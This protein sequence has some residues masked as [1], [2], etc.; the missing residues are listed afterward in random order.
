[1]LT[2]IKL[3]HTAIWAF[4]ATSILALPVVGIL[5]R[6]RWAAIL[7][8]IVLVECGVLAVNGGRCPLSDFATRFTMNRN[9]NFDIYLPIW[10]A[11]QN[12]LI[13]GWLLVAGELV[14]VGCWYRQRFAT[15]LRAGNHSSH[16]P[17]KETSIMAEF[18]A[19]GLYF[20]LVFAVGF[21]LGAIRTMW[22][23]PR[24]GARRAELTETPISS[25]SQSWRPA[26]RFCASQ[27]HTFCQSEL[28]WVASH[29]SSC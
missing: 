10:L 17:T 4:L 19:G 8:A 3:L 26:G 12:K 21:A 23:V 1:M 18:K 29:S 13:F 6:F 2:A 7:T 25:W 22:I 15:S 27:C 16:E 24:I 5:R 20:V 14:L 11:Q 28:G 9:S